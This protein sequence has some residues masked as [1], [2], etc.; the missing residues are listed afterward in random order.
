MTK[1]ITLPTLIQSTIQ[2]ITTTL[3]ESFTTQNKQ[4]I[5]TSLNE[6]IHLLGKLLVLTRYITRNPILHDI[7]CFNTNCQ[8]SIISL[9]NIAHKLLTNAK[10]IISTRKQSYEIPIALNTLL[11]SS[12]ALPNVPLIEIDYQKIMGLI[13]RKIWKF[14]YQCSKTIDCKEMNV[15]QGMFYFQH[16]DVFEVW[17]TINNIDCIYDQSE[18]KWHILKIHFFKS[19]ETIIPKE[20]ISS[21]NEFMLKNYE[22]GKNPVKNLIDYLNKLVKFYYY[23]NLSSS[24]KNM[25][26]KV[27]FPYL[28]FEE[29]HERNQPK[30]S[31]H[32][33]KENS[34]H[35]S[36]STTPNASGNASSG[37]GNTTENKTGKQNANQ[38]NQP[39]S[40][41]TPNGSNGNGTSNPSRSKSTSIPQQTQT[42]KTSE[43]KIY[44]W[45]TKNVYFSYTYNEIT[46]DLKGV[47]YPSI[48]DCQ[49]NVAE[50]LE[51]QLLEYSQRYSEIR[52]KELNDILRKLE[53]KTENKTDN[54]TA[55][56]RT[57]SDIIYSDWLPDAAFDSVRDKEEFKKV[58]RGL[59][60]AT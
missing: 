25:S 14:Y 23:S 60:A 12:Y 59:C 43:L 58:L 11:Q 29:I 17:L 45:K 4:T 46:C 26:L 56:T 53:E 6:S 40:S 34:Q 7:D 24:V 1:Q 33:Q 38:S 9:H 27:Y 30:H 55:D 42:E 15:I 2:T 3:N 36:H 32:K 41:T 16:N 28:N 44:F 48:P 18:I 51:S 52:T 37:N 57:L 13:E 20:L 31:H 8:L 35:G 54:E 22:Y 47:Q 50:S 10:E 21:L 39:V 49:L 5:I 19:S